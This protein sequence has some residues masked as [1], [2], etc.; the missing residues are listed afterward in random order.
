MSILEILFR[1]SGQK[2]RTLRPKNQSIPAGFRGVLEHQTERCIGCGTCAY[3]CSPGAITLQ[4]EPEGGICWQYNALRCTY[5]SRCAEYCPTHAIQL[6]DHAPAAAPAQQGPALV[7]S[8]FMTQHLVEL[9]T[10]ARCGTP[11][12]AIPLPILEDL[13]KRKVPTGE[14]ENSDIPYLMRLCEKCR[15]RVA[16]EHLRDSFIGAPRREGR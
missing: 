10:C 12:S 2:N 11:F 4:T 16:S 3:V 13:M 9:Q 8:G 7:S 15:Q 1:N 5:C 6:V 14:G